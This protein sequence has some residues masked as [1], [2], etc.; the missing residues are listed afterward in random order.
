MVAEPGDEPPG[1]A[2]GPDGLQGER[3]PAG[4][5]ARERVAAGDRLVQEPAAVLGDAEEAGAAAEQPGRQGSWTESGADR[6]VSR[7]TI[8]VGVNP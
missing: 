3:V 7:V 5:V 2:P 4:L 6:Y 1:L 8:A